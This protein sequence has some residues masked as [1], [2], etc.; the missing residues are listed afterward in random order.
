MMVVQR[1]NGS[2]G[3]QHMTSDNLKPA[4][5]EN[6]LS[7]AYAAGTNVVIYNIPRSWWKM[8]GPCCRDAH[9]FYYY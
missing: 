5:H 3:K 9:S 7:D 4:L 2:I 8:D 1:R 6:A